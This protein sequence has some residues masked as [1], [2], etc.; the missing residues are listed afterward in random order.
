MSQ[1]QV[2]SVRRRTYHLSQPKLV[3]CDLS[4]SDDS[5]S[6]SC[7]YNFPFCVI[8]RFYQ[9]GYLIP[10]H[11]WQC[12]LSSVLVDPCRTVLQTLS[13]HHTFSLTT[14][15]WDLSITHFLIHLMSALL[16]AVLSRNYKKVQILQIQPLQL[17][18]VSTDKENSISRFCQGEGKIS[19]TYSPSPASPGL[20]NCS[21]ALSRVLTQQAFKSIATVAFKEYC[22]FLNTG[23]VLQVLSPKMD[24]IL[25][26]VYSWLLVVTA[27]C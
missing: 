16:N 27:Y 9:L 3:Q 24:T 5:V 4:E 25:N 26:C 17:M 18:I 7:P 22:I 13:L 20:W 23:S 14:A 15:F 6:E 8:H 10:L 2:S 21:I 11:S 19:R 1:L 12:W